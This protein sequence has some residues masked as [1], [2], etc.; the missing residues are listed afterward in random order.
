MADFKWRKR[1][2]DQCGETLISE[3]LE[4]LKRASISPSV[5]DH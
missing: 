3:M 4:S 2:L 5:K 1:A